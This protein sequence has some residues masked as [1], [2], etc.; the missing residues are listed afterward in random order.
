[1]F[2]F[3]NLTKRGILQKG[4]FQIDRLT[5]GGFHVNVAQLDESVQVK[6]VVTVFSRKRASTFP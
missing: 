4:E 6:S 5:K 2:I 3:K 1:M